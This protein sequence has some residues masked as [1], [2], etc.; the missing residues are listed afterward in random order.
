[1]KAAKAIH[2][3]VPER[4]RHRNRIIVIRFILL[5]ESYP[6]VMDAIVASFL[7]VMAWL[8][9]KIKTSVAPR[10]VFAPY[11]RCGSWSFK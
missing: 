8:L 9:L 2:I 3:R 10:V 7:Y 6:V 11:K 4:E 5:V 1:M